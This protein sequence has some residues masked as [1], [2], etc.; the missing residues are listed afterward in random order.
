MKHFSK[1]EWLAYGK[2]QTNEKQALMENH[3]LDCDAC[4]QLFLE[5]IDAN[6]V[7]EARTLIPPDFTA[8]TCDLIRTSSRKEEVQPNRFPRRGFLAYYAVAAAITI[9]LTG[10]GV[11]QSWSDHTRMNL[12]LDPAVQT[13][14][15]Y[16][17]ILF[18]WPSR[19]Q[20]K[21]TDWLK[22]VDLEKYKEVK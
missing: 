19:L 17:T 15:K 18:N 9:M 10:G 14:S 2:G 12:Q 11:F 20:E 21:T 1:E 7:E 3:L 6:A 5:G 8:R 13:V 16:E 4:L 22:T